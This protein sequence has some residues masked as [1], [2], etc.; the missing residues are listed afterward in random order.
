[1]QC[2]KCGTEL[3]PDDSFCRKCGAPR[4]EL[5]L[6]FAEAARRFAAL[7]ARYQA[8][9]LDD[10]TYDAELQKLVIVDGAGDRW[11]LGAESG[12]WF[13]HDGRQW[14][15]RDP[16]PTEA[17]PG[18]PLAS[19]ARKGIPW[20]RV[21]IS[22]GGAS[23]AVVVVVIIVSVLAGQ[24]LLASVY[25]LLELETQS[26]VAS[27]AVPIVTR[28][29]S[30]VRPTAAPPARPTSAPQ[31][32]ALPTAQLTPTLQPTGVPTAQPTAPPQPT[33]PPTVQPTLRPDLPFSIRPYD[34]GRDAGVESAIIVQSP[35]L[36]TWEPGHYRWEGVHPASS[37]L[38]VS[39]GWCAYNSEALN[40]AWADMEYEL[41]VDGIV[42]D[43]AQLAETEE[44]EYMSACRR[45][46]GV[47][48]G[49]SPGQHVL[50]WTRHHNAEV[51][52]GDIL[53]PAGDYVFEYVVDVLSV[54][55]DDFGDTSTGWSEEDNENHK[56]WIEDGG[57][58]AFVKREDWVAASFYHLSEYDDFYFQT[59]VRQ[60]GDVPG[61]YGIVFRYQDDDN[62]Y[63]L[64]IST[65]G[66]YEIRK[67]L[68]GDWVAL[69]DW[70]GSSD[71]NQGQEWNVITLVCVGNRIVVYL[72]GEWLVDVTDDSF[73]KG[74]VGLAAN[75]YAGPG[76]HAVFDT[77]TIGEK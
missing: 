71:I 73:A 38:I 44:S 11:M 55:R 37:P 50:V 51:L 5:P 68:G 1:M 34:A 74:Y 63:L 28:T 8:G 17:P 72:N 29:A 36:L 60:M 32:T 65:D 70:E 9:Q 76:L 56:L 49:W 22:C 16:P 42:I 10:P 14:V 23:A 12:A 67:Q 24:Q 27:T 20:K 3:I 21:A 13:W 69:T 26:G 46:Q 33:T 48:A 75:S 25:K 52:M 59:T 43:L 41:T 39:E 31:P 47:L 58:H 64:R 53:L 2:I 66:Y 77:I 7:R 6:R 18:R 61:A 4:S 35:E 62:Y 54:F 57:F 45:Y 40:D 19:P 15:R 30:S